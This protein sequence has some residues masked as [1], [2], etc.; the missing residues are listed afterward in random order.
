MVTDCR[1]DWNFNAWKEEVKQSLNKSW[2]VYCPLV[3]KIN[4]QIC[5]YFH[6]FFQFLHCHKRRISLC[7]VLSLIRGVFSQHSPVKL[8]PPPSGFYTSLLWVPSVWMPKWWCWERR[9][10]GRPAWWS[11]TFITASW[12]ARTRTWVSAV[13]TSVRCGWNTLFLMSYIR[14]NVWHW[15]NEIMYTLSYSYAAVCSYKLNDV[16]FL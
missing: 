4:K 15:N 16:A 3:K 10:W 6:L 12:W 5:L 14:N 13:S 9:A 11:D 2:K 8:T 7:W 1:V